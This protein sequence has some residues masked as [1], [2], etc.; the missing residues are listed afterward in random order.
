MVDAHLLFLPGFCPFRISL[1]G[2]PGQLYLPAIRGLSTAEGDS[3][4]HNS[5]KIARHA[6]DRQEI[7]EHR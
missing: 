6:N 4:T 3:R 2:S 1:L 7:D 5:V